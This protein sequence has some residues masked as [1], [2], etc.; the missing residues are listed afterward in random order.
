MN[1]PDKRRQNRLEQIRDVKEALLRVKTL[2]QPGA[3]KMD[4][5]DCCECGDPQCVWNKYDSVED[6]VFGFSIPEITKDTAAETKP[7]SSSN[8]I[9][10]P[11]EDATSTKVYINNTDTPIEGVSRAVLE[12]DAELD[13]P[14]LKL[15]IVA[16][17]IKIKS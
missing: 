12:Y 2:L 6:Q 9:F 10:S 7:S 4:K 14:I 15:E 5:P 13:I 3:I 16:P 11:G 8:V 1:Q 17:Q